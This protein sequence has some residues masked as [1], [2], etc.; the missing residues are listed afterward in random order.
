MSS[1]TDFSISRIYSCKKC[2]CAFVVS[3][4]DENL[5]LLQPSM[6]CPNAMS[7]EGKI[8]VYATT[9]MDFKE[10]IRISALHLYQA[11]MGAGLPKE[12]KCSPQEVKKLL[13]GSTIA[14]VELQNCPDPKRSIILSLT[15][16][17]GKVLHFASSTKG[18]TIF[19][20]TEAL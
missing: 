16:N 10:A 1:D 14:E 6:R 7:C 3:G 11:S 9:N 19:K 15:L 12:K 18:A 8:R 13:V 20:I 17:N 4:S 5:K 2:R